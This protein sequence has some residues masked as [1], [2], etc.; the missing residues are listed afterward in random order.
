MIKDHI[1]NILLTCILLALL[2]ILARMPTA[3]DTISVDVDNTSLDVEV[4]NTY[5]LEVEISR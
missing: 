4:T 1:T 5:P 2:T 3:N